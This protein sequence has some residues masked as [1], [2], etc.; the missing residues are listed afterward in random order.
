M[1]TPQELKKLSLSVVTGMN[2]NGGEKMNTIYFKT[3]CKL[4]DMVIGGNKGVEGSPSGRFINIVGDNLLVDFLGV[5]I[6]R[7][8]L[9]VRSL[10]CYRQVL[11]L[12]LTIYCTRA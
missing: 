5:A 2:Y 12:W 1:L 4:F 11:R 3:G 8:S 10:F 7:S 6:R 9:L